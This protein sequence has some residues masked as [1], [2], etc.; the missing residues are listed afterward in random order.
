MIFKYRFYKVD[1]RRVIV[2]LKAAYYLIEMVS[3]RGLTVVGRLY[4]VECR[5]QQ[6]FSYIAASS[7]PIHAFLEFF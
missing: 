4:G 5:F 6:Y 7:A 1:L 3:D 2:S